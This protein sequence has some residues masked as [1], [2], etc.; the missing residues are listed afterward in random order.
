MDLKTIEKGTIIVNIVVTVIVI[1]LHFWGIIVFPYEGNFIF[2]IFL[3]VFLIIS[4][5]IHLFYIL[6]SNIDYAK[7][8]KYILFVLI[9]F[10]VGSVVF[11]EV[12]QGRLS[13]AKF[14]TACNFFLSVIVAIGLIFGGEKHDE[15][16]KE[17]I[18]DFF[19]SRQ[20][21]DS[22]YPSPTT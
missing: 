17:A 18:H 3:I 2:R 4:A 12:I 6:N 15:N 7:T 10:I 9:P 11:I 1:A 5:S 16:I 20:F 8:I 21:R 14:E 13:D 22:V 19:K